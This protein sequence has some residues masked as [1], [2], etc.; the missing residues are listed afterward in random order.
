[1]FTINNEW[2]KLPTKEEYLKRNN[3]NS[4][5][6]IYCNSTTVIDTGLSNM[7]DHRR[8]IIC[9]TC[10]AVLYREND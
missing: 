9:S 2:E 6:C 7:I 8:K 1:M 5:K 10:K 3:L 4:F